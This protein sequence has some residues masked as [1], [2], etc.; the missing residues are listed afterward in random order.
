MGILHFRHRAIAPRSHVPQFSIV[1][2]PLEFPVL[3]ATPE[4]KVDI[5]GATIVQCCVHCFDLAVQRLQHPLG[6]NHVLTP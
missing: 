5:L 6:I 3:S 2:A 4:R 1:P